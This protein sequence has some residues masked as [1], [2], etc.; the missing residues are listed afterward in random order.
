MIT[1]IDKED[2]ELLRKLNYAPR[3]NNIIALGKSGNVIGFVE[4]F[5]EASILIKDGALRDKVSNLK[6]IFEAM[7]DIAKDRGIGEI[8]VFISD[9]S[10]SDILKKHFG[11]ENCRGEALVLR[12]D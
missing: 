9:P 11:F 10:F 4:L 1:P 3:S 5:A 7:K 8:Y 2:I 12:I 6:D